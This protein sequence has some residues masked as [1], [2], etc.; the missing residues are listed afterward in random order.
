MT[1]RQF[2]SSIQAL[3]ENLVRDPGRWILSIST[4]EASTHSL[5]VV[6]Y[7][8]GSLEAGISTGNRPGDIPL[9]R[10]ESDILK[11]LGWTKPP[12]SGQSG[13]YFTEP[14]RSPSASSVATRLTL[15][16]R[17]V[18]GAKAP[19]F[20]T[21]ALCSSRQRGNTPASERPLH[22]PNSQLLAASNFTAPSP[23]VDRQVIGSP[24]PLCAFSPSGQP[25]A[26]YYWI[27]YPGH[28][29]PSNGFSAWKYA[30]TAV[31]ITE[32]LWQAR[33]RARV[34]W[35]ASLA[36]HPFRWDIDHPPVVL[37]L[38]YVAYGAC[39]SCTWLV[40]ANSSLE[41]AV[42]LS[43]AH[44]IENGTDREFVSSLRVP[45]SE[46]NGPTDESLGRTHV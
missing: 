3:I 14:T 23:E 24:S 18:F 45:I 10:T 34:E 4:I 36:E 28:V 35:E 30:T 19:S 32:A 25:W 12:F 38:P 6:V 21:L 29:R 26:N 15:T 22:E 37:W 8:D 31:N 39:L 46:R 9:L 20:V 33:E 27:L 1:L 40:D 44:T 5:S 43:K 13:W 7:E 16:L 41:S 42:E 2:S 17:E 11:H